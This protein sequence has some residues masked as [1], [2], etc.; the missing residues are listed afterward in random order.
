MCKL[1][2]G[3]GVVQSR[4]GK[5]VDG[6]KACVSTKIEWTAGIEEVRQGGLSRSMDGTYC[7]KAFSLS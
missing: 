7:D 6:C 4:A 1:S 3:T 5:D 2:M